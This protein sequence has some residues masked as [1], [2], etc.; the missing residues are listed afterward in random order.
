M[1]GYYRASKQD[2]QD[3][4]NA[5]VWVT[6]NRKASRRDYI[7]SFAESL[8]Q[9]MY[10]RG[11][12]MSGA[13][14]KGHLVCAKWLYAICVREIGRNTHWD[15]L[16]YPDPHHRAYPEDRDQF[17]M[18]ITPEVIS[19]FMVH[20]RNNEDLSLESKVGQRVAIELEELLWTYVYVNDS[21]QGFIVNHILES[22]SEENDKDYDMNKSSK[23]GLDQYLVDTSDGWHR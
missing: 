22:L 15:P 19:E 21:R 5:K 14:K 23:G 4:L 9:M 18:T 6:G 12:K 11:Y 2:F 17:D 8:T 16:S 3:W 10:N 13:W 1:I 7:P 20:W